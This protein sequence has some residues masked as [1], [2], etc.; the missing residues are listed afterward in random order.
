MP[1]VLIHKL[2][3]LI[4]TFPLCYGTAN[5]QYYTEAELITIHQNK[6][7][8]EA[9]ILEFKRYLRISILEMEVDSFTAQGDVA[10]H[11]GDVTTARGY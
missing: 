11:K 7:A 2:Y 5:A 9:T 6:T 1:K 10:A 4:F 8:S 3:L